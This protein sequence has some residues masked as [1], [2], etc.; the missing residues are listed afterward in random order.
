MNG[1]TTVLTSATSTSR[2]LRTT[3]PISIVKQFN[4]EEHDKLRWNLKAQN[5]E[6]IIIVT[7]FKKVV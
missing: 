3:V 4:L 1:E 7:P 2:S 6:I 5:N